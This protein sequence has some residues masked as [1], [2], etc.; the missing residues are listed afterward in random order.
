MAWPH[1]T[2]LAGCPHPSHRHATASQVLPIAPLPYV[3]RH[4]PWR[5]RRPAWGATAA[6]Q[7]LKR[8]VAV[9]RTR[10]QWLVRPDGLT[11]PVTLHPSALL[12]LLG[13][14]RD[15]AYAAWLGDLRQAGG[16]AGAAARR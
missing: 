16:F 14:E 9:M 1:G 6:R 4:T 5:N 8:P 15:A 10:G 11:V 3:Q 2:C 13:E 7:L 12:R